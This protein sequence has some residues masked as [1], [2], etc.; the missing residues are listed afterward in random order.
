MN[1]QAA[2]I[3]LMISLAASAG[4]APAGGPDAAAPDDLLAGLAWQLALER[5]GFSPGVLDGRPGPKTRLA[6]REFQRVRGLP[7]TGELDA[8]TARALGVR[9]AEALTEYT[10]AAADLAQIGPVPTDW[11]EKA[12]LPR[13]SY[14]SLDEALAEKFHCTRALLSHLNG[15]ANVARLRPGETIDVPNLPPPPEP[16]LCEHLEVNLAEKVIRA[17]CS[18][19]LVALF[20]CS[21]AADRA[22]RPGG[23]AQVTVISEEPTYRFDP[24]MWPEVKGIRDVLFIPPGPR[25]PVGLCW[26][27]LSLPGYGIHGSPAPEL[28]GKTGSHGCFRLTNWDALRLARMVRVGTPVQ[29]SD[30]PA[31]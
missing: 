21:I 11:R 4:P 29:F 3:W 23:A 20:H 31:P 24:K 16:L 30:S 19:R 6:T 15:G 18:D 13:L 27:G 10:V 17:V 1:R 14:P 22:K 26:I 12:R 28:I 9:P 25:S 7:R 2:T 5:V 8:A